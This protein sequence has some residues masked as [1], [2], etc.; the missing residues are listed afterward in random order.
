MLG[1]RIAD[2][3]K[4]KGI[5]QEELAEILLTSRQAVSK[6]ERGESDPDIG[7]LKDIAVYFNVSIDYLLGYDME[8]ASVNN[9]IERTKKC[10]IN[11]TFDISLDEIRM[12]V[13][14]N[15]NNF[16]LL[17]AVIEYLC[18]YY[19]INHKEEVVD[20][21]IQYIKTAIPL[22]RPSDNQGVSLNDLH[23]TIAEIYVLRKQFELAK[24]YLIDN[25]VI[26]ADHLLSECELNLLHYEETEKITS[27]MFLKAISMIINGNITQ[28]RV[29]LRKNQEKAALDLVDWSINF[30]ESVGKNEDVMLNIIYILHFIKA[31]CQN[32]LGMDYSKSL[33]FLRENRDKTSG[34][35][36]ENDGIRFYNN[37]RI[38]LTSS[39]GD[40][41]IDLYNEI[42]ELKKSGH[43]YESGLDIYNKIYNE[44]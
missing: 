32:S 19:L 5:S 7:R 21:L 16:D 3:R 6:W 28:I 24:S 22:Y 26:D 38:V 10:A 1:E 9:F 14:R 23:K 42:Q 44:D 40:I 37:K 39:E 25:K 41:K 11:N 27:D 30:V 17:M 4:S 12:I 33:Q 15:K 43:N 31:T 18:E 29:F 20:L 13:S 36:S 2:L 8:S 34:Y 35:K